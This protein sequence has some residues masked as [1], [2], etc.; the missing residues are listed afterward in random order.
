M[1]LDFEFELESS[2]NLGQL[3]QEIGKWDRSDPEDIRLFHHSEIL[4][5]LIRMKENRSDNSIFSTENQVIEFSDNE[6]LTAVFGE[7]GIINV[8]FETLVYPEIDVKCIGTE[9]KFLVNLNLN[10]SPITE[11]EADDN[12]HIDFG[13]SIPNY[14]SN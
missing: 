8:D 1:L 5:E 2:T 3:R 9:R 11:V 6:L 4:R 13:F 7:V 12:K 14:V 10:D